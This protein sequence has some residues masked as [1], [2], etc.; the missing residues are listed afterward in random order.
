MNSSKTQWRAGFW[1]ETFAH[2]DGALALNQSARHEI[3]RHHGLRLPCSLLH[4]SLTIIYW[5]WFTDW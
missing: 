4:M 5:L 1:R 2:I 3:G